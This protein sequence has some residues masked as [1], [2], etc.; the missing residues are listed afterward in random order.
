MTDV[1]ERFEAFKSEFRQTDM[2]RAM[3][4]EREDSPWH[5]EQNVAV[6]T[7]MLL[8]WYR[9]N[10]FNSRSD[11]QRMLTLVGCLFH[12]VGKPV[13][14]VEKFSEERSNYRAYHGHEKISAR[15]WV[16]YMSDQR[17]R[18]TLRFDDYDISFV[19]LMLEHHV[20]FGLKNSQKRIALKKA[21][22]LRMGDMG[23]RSWLDLLLSDQHGRISDDQ[24]EKLA[25]VDVWMNDWE[26]I[27][28]TQ[29]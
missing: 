14:K 17:A 28:W 1:V 25:A 29:K 21:F 15:M 23:H 24:N 20:P 10:L 6:H 19:A 22:Y 3:L 18:N 9:N 8:S 11:K 27:E 16:N 12:D 13:A 5:R 4:L 2:W 7:D 26:K